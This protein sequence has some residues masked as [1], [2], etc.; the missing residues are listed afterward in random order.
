LA[1]FCSL[2]TIAATDSSNKELNTVN[3]LGKVEKYASV[4]VVYE[5]MP[6]VELLI[7]KLEGHGFDSQSGNLNF[8]ST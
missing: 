3:M 6:W 2:L 4:I 5:L 8:L 7:Y 1:H